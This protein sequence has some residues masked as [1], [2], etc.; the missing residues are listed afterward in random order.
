MHPPPPPPSLHVRIQPHEVSH[1]KKRAK[2]EKQ[3]GGGGGGGGGWAGG[4]R[5]P[6]GCA[7]NLLCFDEDDWRFRLLLPGAGRAEGEANKRR[8]DKGG[9]ASG[10]DGKS[11]SMMI[12][13]QEDGREADIEGATA[14]E[15]GETTGVKLENLDERRD[16]QREEDRCAREKAL[17]LLYSASLNILTKACGGAR[18]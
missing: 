18:R 9:V 8:Y 15:E 2:R 5:P 14:E 7:A 12:E 16:A 17:E 10:G 4:G 1:A 3:G 13:E 11:A 6:P